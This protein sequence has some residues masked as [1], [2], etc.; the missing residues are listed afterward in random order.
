MKLMIQ[1]ILIM[2]IISN[3]CNN[4]L[5]CEYFAS[6]SMYILFIYVNWFTLLNCKWLNKEMGGTRNVWSLYQTRPRAA[7]ALEGR[8]RRARRREPSLAA[9]LEEEQV[10]QQDAEEDEE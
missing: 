2:K 5:F 10:P 1:L 8:R 6:I 3:A 4:M 9:T 7:K